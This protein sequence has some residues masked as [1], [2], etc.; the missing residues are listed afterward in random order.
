MQVIVFGAGCFW[1][2]EQQFSE[3]KGVI[4]TVVGYA[5]GYTEQ[6]TYEQICSGKTGHAEVVKVEFDEGEIS[7]PELFDFFF[8]MHN[9]TTKNRQGPDIGSQY[10]SIIFYKNELQKLVAIASMR[11]RQ[12]KVNKDIVTEIVPFTKF[13]MAEDYHQQY[14]KKNPNYFCGI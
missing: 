1:G 7:L 6:P 4:S 9:P 2:V 13:Y 10:R 5:G 12:L 3:I 11:K 8:T 14:F